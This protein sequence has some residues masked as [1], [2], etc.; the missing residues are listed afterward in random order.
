MDYINEGISYFINDW[1]IK[2]S[3][4]NQVAYSNLMMVDDVNHKELLTI[5]IDNIHNEINLM[6]TPTYDYVNA[7]RTLVLSLTNNKVNI[8]LAEINYDSILSYIDLVKKTTSYNVQIIGS[9][10]VGNSLN[11]FDIGIDTFRANPVLTVKSK[12]ING[13]ESLEGDLGIKDTSLVSVV[14]H[15]NVVWMNASEL[16]L[17]ELS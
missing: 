1:I 14:K 17:G 4:R 9:S 6:E 7:I 15:N 2:S 13:F 12:Y 5:D 11:V 3:I 8:D 16:T 10:I